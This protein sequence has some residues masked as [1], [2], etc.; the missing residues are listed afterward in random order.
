MDG[1]P[2]MMSAIPEG[3]DEVDLIEDTQFEETQVIPETQFEAQ[4]DILVPD[5]NFRS[6]SVAPMDRQILESTK[7]NSQSISAGPQEDLFK[8]SLLSRP[9]S[10]GKHPGEGFTYTAAPAKA[11]MNFGIRM[12]QVQM[13]DDVM[14]TGQPNR[15]DLEKSQTEGQG[16]TAGL[17]SAHA[18]QSPD[19]HATPPRTT[20]AKQ[21][22][23]HAKQSPSTV[24]A[25]PAAAS[26]AQQGHFKTNPTQRLG[27]EY[28]D[29]V[30][31]STTETPLENHGRQMLEN[32][33]QA[34]SQEPLDEQV[35]PEPYDE[36]S[37]EQPRRSH[38]SRS[39]VQDS[40]VSTNV[41][42]H[43]PQ[44]KR[45]SSGDGKSKKTSR[46]SK[47]KSKAKERGRAVVASLPINTDHHVGGQDR[48]MPEPDAL[49]LP[50]INV[51]QSAGINQ[52]RYANR[53]PDPNGEHPEDNLTGVQSADFHDPMQTDE[54]D[55]LDIPFVS[56]MTNDRD[57]MQ[58]Q[59][60]THAPAT[61]IPSNFGLPNR[62]NGNPTSMSRAQA[63]RL[64]ST[65]SHNHPRTD[66]QNLSA[67]GPQVPR[68]L[69]SPS[70]NTTTA[71]PP[72][73]PQPL[74][75][76]PMLD[77]GSRTQNRT[78]QDADHTFPLDRYDHYSPAPCPGRSSIIE[79][80]SPQHQFGSMANASSGPS[81]AAGRVS[82][83]R[84]SK[85]VSSS[86]TNS[87]D[88]AP[89]MSANG[90]QVEELSSINARDPAL[91]T[92]SRIMANPP[93]AVDMI[94][95]F[96]ETCC[97]ELELELQTAA[98]N[99]LR[100]QLALKDEIIRLTESG[101]RLQVELQFTQKS[102][103]KAEANYA[104]EQSKSKAYNIDLLK[105][106]KFA[107]GAAKD[108]AK[109][110]ATSTNLSQEVNTLREEMTKLKEEI[111]TKAQVVN[112]CTTAKEHV[113][114]LE[115]QNAALAKELAEK[116]ER[117]AEENTRCSQLQEQT[118]ASIAEQQAREEEMK[119]VLQK[120]TAIEHT[121]KPTVDT[122]A[123]NQMEQ[124]MKQVGELHSRQF[125]G[126]PELQ[127]LESLISGLESRVLT[128]LSELHTA[129]AES[130]E[131]AAAVG[132][133][134]D[135]DK[136]FREEFSS[137][138]SGILS[139]QDL[140]MKLA[141][142]KELKATADER[143]AT[144]T[145]QVADLQ[146]QLASL[147]EKEG[148]Q[149]EKLIQLQL[150]LEE[151]TAPNAEELVD[152]QAKLDAK[153]LELQSVRAVEAAK[154]EEIGKLQEALQ[155]RETECAA[156]LCQK[157]ES[158][159]KATDQEQLYRSQLKADH[160]RLMQARQAEFDNKLR[161]ADQKHRKE[162][163][164]AQ[165]R[166]DEASSEESSKYKDAIFKK[167]EADHASALEVLQEDA[168][169]ALDA[170]TRKLTEESN[171]KIEVMRADIQEKNRREKEHLDRRIA[172][173]DAARQEAV[174]DLKQAKREV[175]TN[176]KSH[177]EKIKAGLAEQRARLQDEAKAER[178]RLDESHR[179]EQER[180]RQR[181]AKSEAEL[182][183]LR[184][185][186]SETSQQSLS[187]SVSNVTAYGHGI[188]SFRKPVQKG[189]YRR[190]SGSIA[191][192]PGFASQDD[193]GSRENI[194]PT[195]TLSELDTL[196]SEHVPIYHHP[197]TSSS[198][199]DIPAEPSPHTGQVQSRI[200]RELPVSRQ[201]SQYSSG[202]QG[203]LE[204][205]TSLTARPS[206]KLQ[207][208]PNSANRMA[209]QRQINATS[210]AVP[211]HVNS[212]HRTSLVPIARSSGR[213]SRTE[214]QD[215]GL[216]S[217]MSN[218]RNFQTPS[219][220]ET[221]L[222]GS[223]HRTP[224]VSNIL[225]DIWNGRVEVEDSQVPGRRKVSDSL[226][227][228][229]PEND[230]AQSI[231]NA[232]LNKTSPPFVPETQAQRLL[233]TYRHASKQQAEIE[234]PSEAMPHQASTA[235][236]RNRSESSRPT[237]PSKRAKVS[238]PATQLRRDA[239][240]QALQ[241]RPRLSSML[242]S[243]S[244]SQSARSGPNGSQSQTQATSNFTSAARSSAPKTPMNSRNLRASNQTHRY[245]LRIDKELV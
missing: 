45:K 94:G 18:P 22:P 146:A 13:T 31:N 96:V 105:A 150:R 34:D 80:R 137:L 107:D 23:H 118:S 73:A 141:D 1:F 59:S 149:N 186:Q 33:W 152:L 187:T 35:F 60:Q 159:K 154:E 87:G 112:E 120:L 189:T 19:S 132:A 198:L 183:N 227:F 130:P 196:L 238:T 147:H 15:S 243:Q 75:Q 51:A 163:A 164:A 61:A 81:V 217:R 85:P 7:N 30:V 20:K 29:K 244:G 83:G 177:S 216:R 4:D 91:L 111:A 194:P 28:G 126:P 215:P 185:A 88:R 52:P 106:K 77:V 239:Q 42:P 242:E 99:R 95:G 162:L 6:D 71:Q 98:D 2:N 202:T 229:T 39:E 93:R 38:V 211:L 127:K 155:A 191:G 119:A 140:H 157:A 153:E 139:T 192:R 78:G 125:L 226:R 53:H 14:E 134:Y 219:R 180:F 213:G 208:L 36:Q 245:N 102:Q 195:R 184:A 190:H 21:K 228:Q 5:D 100:E 24:V 193:V 124:L 158:E 47:S 65:Q 121:L 104:E 110:K 10:S 44:R 156:L 17:N 86:L 37:Y 231:S 74:K 241:S 174:R 171:K 70:Q 142:L 212:S 40:G 49:N 181:I 56:Q 160:N 114:I 84:V 224:L 58:Q 235:K 57:F 232:Q 3:S 178:S 27:Q 92:T 172:D 214:I 25:S 79:T 50:F 168:K 143:C 206:S 200:L 148:A 240:S 197:R 151:H 203:R 103:G 145:Q 236:K 9:K 175:D 72:T 179:K 117:L 169:A 115:G 225:P 116:T 113:R 69:T 218:P 165:K 167:L 67:I 220:G 205:T 222:V 12:G 136:R 131:V 68:M 135:F 233:I 62:F 76:Q 170:Q 173:M 207:P 138:K 234:A 109:E 108:F 66:R 82:E 133:A 182:A 63:N 64:Q 237:Q 230:I 221:R 161:Q 201:G 210:G 8:S 176:L 97:K 123:E 16:P 11:N 90:E 128:R 89:S 41:L 54:N 129:T 144:K 223:S 48:H 46:N 166:S 122:A 32:E 209:A 101:T 204:G 43:Q 55:V 199:S 26:G 188:T